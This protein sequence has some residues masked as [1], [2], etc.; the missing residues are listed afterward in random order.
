MSPTYHQWGQG[1]AFLPEYF[2]MGYDILQGDI[3]RR[4]VGT[5]FLPE[6]L[7]LPII[8]ETVSHPAEH[9]DHERH[10][11]TAGA[12]RQDADDNE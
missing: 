6:I 12:W 8:N 5:V 7:N 4:E 9:N 11:S 2:R 10:G 3:L 1:C